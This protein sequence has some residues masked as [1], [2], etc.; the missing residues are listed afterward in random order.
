MGL[1]RFIVRVVVAVG[2]LGLAPGCG[3]ISDAEL[4][5]RLD[6]DDDGLLRKFDCDDNDPSITVYQYY[7]DLDQDGYGDDNAAFVEGCELRDGLSERG[8]DCDDARP[9]VN[10]AGTEVCNQLDDDCNG[11][12]DDD[13]TDMRTFYQDYDGD[14]LGDPNDPVTT[15][16]PPE[17]YVINASDCDDSDATTFG[18]STWYT[19]DDGDGWGNPRATSVAC[20][21]PEG[22]VARGGDCDDTNGDIH[23]YAT[24]VCDDDMVDEDCD[25]VANDDDISVDLSNGQDVWPDADGDGFGNASAPSVRCAPDPVARWVDNRDDCDDSDPT[26]TTEDCPYLAVSAGGVSSCAVRG[27]LRIVCWGDDNLALNAPDGTFTDV[28]VGLDHGCGLELG[29]TL[30][31]WGETGAD[32]FESDDVLHQVD[33]DGSYTC[34]LTDKEDLQCWANGIE[35]RLGVADKVFVDFEVGTS[36]G[37][38]LLD[39]GEGKCLGACDSGECTVPSGPWLDLAAGREFSCGVDESGSLEC[40]GDHSASPP[41]GIFDTTHAFGRNVCASGPD[42]IPVCWSSTVAFPGIGSPTESFERWD[43]GAAHGCGI[44]SSDQRLACWGNDSYGQASPPE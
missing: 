29:G 25:G 13:V 26:I 22:T 5:D 39:D 16:F 15:C 1:S 35:Y 30:A 43:V 3:Y 8:G 14:G 27:D 28:A 11:R 12:A 41:S 10:P 19:D 7:V 2:L 20:V 40:W 32:T 6:A 34:S 38:G 18:V 24:E 4:K 9:H 44:R 31:C 23:P 17:G 36:H 33:I 37:C 42:G 21:A